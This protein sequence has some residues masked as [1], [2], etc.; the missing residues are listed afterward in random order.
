M[1]KR[2]RDRDRGRETYGGIR[3]TET[4]RHV[5]RAA[6]RPSYGREA[7]DPLDLSAFEVR[8]EPVGFGYV[9]PVASLAR[10]QEMRRPGAAGSMQSRKQDEPS[11]SDQRR[12]SKAHALRVSQREKYVGPNQVKTAKPEHLHESSATLRKER[13]R[14]TCKERPKVNKG[15][16]G[17]RKFVPW[18]SRRS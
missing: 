10:P 3:R 8:D 16:G 12:V 2:N 6:D 15:S 17:S 4:V 14:E 18:C 11:R 7:Y 1:A 9:P 13:L 5:Q